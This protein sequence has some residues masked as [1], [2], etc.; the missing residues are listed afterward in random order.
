MMEGE[1]TEV[2]PVQKMDCGIA[3]FDKIVSLLQ[4]S[5]APTS[6]ANLQD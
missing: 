1:P 4:I 5:F 6:N 2:V 3:G